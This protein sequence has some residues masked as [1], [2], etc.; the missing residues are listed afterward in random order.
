MKK[1]NLK[2]MVAYV[3]VA[4]LTLGVFSM[5]V[6]AAEVEEPT[7]KDALEAAEDAGIRLDEATR[8]QLEAIVKEAADSLDIVEEGVESEKSTFVSFAEHPVK[9]VEEDGEGHGLRGVAVKTIALTYVADTENLYVGITEDGTIYRSFEE[10]SEPGFYYAVCMYAGDDNN[11]PSVGYGI[12]VILPAEE[13]E[14]PTEA[15][16]TVPEEDPTEPSE[17]PTEAPTEAPT[18]EPTEAPTEAPVEEPTEAPATDATTS[19]EEAP[20]T[21]DES[22]IMA[23]AAVTV[24]ALCGMAAIVM[25]K[26]NA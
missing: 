3:L 25:K 5:N 15:P 10:P 1:F 24:V 20:K 13:A 12:V 2:K 26:R 17:E 21:G 4:M 18:E 22:N 8:D 11:Y 9:V 7:F 23:Y 16:T 19:E 14:E 6:A